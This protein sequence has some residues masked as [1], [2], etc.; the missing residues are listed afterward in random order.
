MIDLSDDGLDFLSVYLK[1]GSKITVPIV[2]NISMQSH[3]PG[4]VFYMYDGRV[5]MGTLQKD[6]NF[7]MLEGNSGIA[8]ERNYPPGYAC[9]ECRQEIRCEP[10]CSRAP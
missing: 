10:W 6:R 2:E 4:Y 7:K 3:P 1:I 5:R 8:Q 9:P